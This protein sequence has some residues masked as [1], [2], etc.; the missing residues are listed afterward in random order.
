M[1]AGS[2][3]GRERAYNVSP[4]LQ[5]GPTEENRGRLSAMRNAGARD[6][7]SYRAAY[8]DISRVSCTA[9]LRRSGVLLERLSGSPSRAGRDVSG[10]MARRAAH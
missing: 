4:K 7:L 10:S 8:P 1:G 5:D 6:V 9:V 2:V 3:Q